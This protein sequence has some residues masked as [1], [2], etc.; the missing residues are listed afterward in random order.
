M[1]SGRWAAG[2]VVDDG[3]LTVVTMARWRWVVAGGSWRVVRGGNGAW[4]WAA[5]GGQ[6]W[7]AAG[8]WCVKGWWWAE[9]V[10]GGG[11]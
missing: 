2:G 8:G 11:W 7:L 1:G 9:G 10:A 6:W 3:W 4:R 5:V